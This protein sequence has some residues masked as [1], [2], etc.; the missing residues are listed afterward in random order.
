[1]VSVR[2]GAHQAGG[3]EVLRAAGDP[4][5]EA[6]MGGGHGGKAFLIE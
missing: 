5:G 3:L 1:M 4:D 6:E 2:L